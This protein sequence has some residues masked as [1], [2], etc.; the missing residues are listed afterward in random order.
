[1]PMDKRIRTLSDTPHTISYVIRKRQQIDSLSEL[2]EDKR[3]TDEILWDGSPE[4]LDEW[5]KTVMD[6]NYKSTV[7]GI[8]ISEIE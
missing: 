8:D 4:D 1:V 5:L 3:P 2:P 6:S 7:T